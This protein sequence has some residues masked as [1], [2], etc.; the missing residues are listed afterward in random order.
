[1]VIDSSALV[2]IL[3]GEPDRVRLQGAIEGDAVRLVSAVT[4]LESGM[5]MAGRLGEQ[6]AIEL[7]NLLTW[8]DATIVP[9]DERQADI[10]RDAF[11]RYGKGRHKAG[12]NFGDCA[13]YALAIAEAEP[14][15]FKGTDFAATDVECVPLGE[16]GEG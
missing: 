2:A 16:G 5:V 12:L 11:L 8:I 7:Q 15:L 4:K 10:A 9:F 3:L 1:M 6:G 13:A 14:L